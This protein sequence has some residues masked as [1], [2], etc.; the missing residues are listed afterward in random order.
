MPTKADQLALPAVPHYDLMPPV[1]SQPTAP[2]RYTENYDEGNPKR[3]TEDNKNDQ[4]KSRWERI[5]NDPVAF[6]TLCLAIIAGVQAALFVWQLILIKSSLNDAKLAAK[7][8]G[9]SA[10]GTLETVK[11]LRNAQ[12]PYLSP[13]DPALRNY[14]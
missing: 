4:P 3:S 10:R 6:V 2:P 13:F 11:V 1:L 9:D 14:H 5:T 8:A 12:R 7:A